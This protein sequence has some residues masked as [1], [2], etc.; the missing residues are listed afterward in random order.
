MIGQVKS[1]FIV[2]CIFGVPMLVSYCN[3]P[4]VQESTP[5]TKPTIAAVKSNSFLPDTAIRDTIVK[6]ISKHTENSTK[7][8]KKVPLTLIIDNLESPT[9][10]IHVSLYG[11]KNKFPDPLGQLKKYQFKSTGKKITA[12]IT[13]LPFGEYA[14]AIYQDE[15]NNGKIDKNLLGV[16]TEHYAFSNNYKPTVR[17]PKY[18]NCKFDYSAKNNVVPMTMIK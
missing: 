3:Y 1:F 6:K 9:A 18:E 8:V 13:D 4:K 7:A 5:D 12:H 16:P 2:S 10:I 11:S 15:N 17:A 14:I